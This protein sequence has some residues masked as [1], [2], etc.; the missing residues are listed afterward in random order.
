MLA[1]VLKVVLLVNEDANLNTFYL[2]KRNLEKQFYF[3]A[4]SEV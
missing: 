3:N 4:V 2:E 1:V